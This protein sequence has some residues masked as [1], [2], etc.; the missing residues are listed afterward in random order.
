[1]SEVLILGFGYSAARIAVRLAHRGWRVSGTA[2][3]AGGALRVRSAGHTGLVFDGE[4]PEPA[5]AEAIA[6]ATHI[7]VSIPPGTDGDPTLRW[8]AGGIARSASLQWIGYLS[9]VGVYGDRGG[10]TVDETATPRPGSERSRQRVV[11]E[12]EWLEIGRRAGK[13]VALIR[14]AGIYGPGRSAVDNILAGTARR[15]LKPGQVFNRIHVADLAA[16]VEAA[17]VQKAAGV[18]HACD[19]LPA[20]PEDVIEHAAELLGRPVPEGI[21]FE[22]AALSPMGRSFYSECKRVSSEAT[23]RRLGIKLAMPTY[24]EGLAAI[25]GDLRGG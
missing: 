14:I 10:G 2:T 19:T 23:L 17:A 5:L 21:P 18:L 13:P 4:G 15:I 11:V 8:H 1:M 3:S 9:T 25:V 16:I 22:Q 12:E 6:R 20:P 7:V 24:R